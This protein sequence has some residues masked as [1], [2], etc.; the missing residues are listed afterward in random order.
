MLCTCSCILSKA[1]PYNTLTDAVKRYV[2]PKQVS[3]RNVLF[4]QCKLVAVT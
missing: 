2:S 1:Q 4:D 3:A